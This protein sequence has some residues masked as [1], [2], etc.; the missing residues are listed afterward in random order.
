MTVSSVNEGR[1]GKQPGP[2]VEKRLNAA[3]VKKAPPG[4]HTDGGGLYLQVD[5]SG[6]RRWILRVVVHGVRRDLGLGSANVVSLA[7][8]RD[9]SHEMRRLIAAGG[10]PKVRRRE[11]EGRATTFAELA[12]RVHHSKFKDNKSNGKHVA[13]WIKTLETYAFPVLGDL[14]VEDVSQDDIERV[15]DPIWTTKPETARRVLQRI[16]TVFDHACGRGLR[17]RGNPTTGMRGLMRKQG[18]QVK[19]FAAIDFM[20]IDRL[21]ST[22]KDSNDVGALALLFTLFT[23]SRSGPV[24][25]ATWS[26]MDAGLEIWSIPAEKMKTKKE[27][28]VPLSIPAR[29]VLLRAQERRT[30]GSDLVFPSPSKPKNMISENTMRKLLQ[31]IFPGSTVHG[32]RSTFRTWVTEIIRV[33]QDVAELCLAHSLGGKVEQAVDFHPEL[34]RVFHRELTHLEIMLV[35]S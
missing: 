25:A 11:N 32:L 10:N 20:E 2:H 4:R 8:A 16:K 29:D 1:G 33:D 6:A 21:F 7:D 9:K 12:K 5:G 24:R 3:F 34:T 26:E 15:I 14:S 23:A 17:S 28:M 18:D 31:T 30:N 19:H 27:F 13:Q 22:F 35:G